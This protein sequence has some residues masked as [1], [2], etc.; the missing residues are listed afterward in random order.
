MFTENY[1]TDI[2]KQ[3]SQA[4]QSPAKER[5]EERVAYLAL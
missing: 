4:H 1:R 3:Q 5:H 2:L